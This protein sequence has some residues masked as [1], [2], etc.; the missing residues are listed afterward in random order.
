MSRSRQP[1]PDVAAFTWFLNGLTRPARIRGMEGEA[2]PDPVAQDLLATADLAGLLSQ[3]HALDVR[4]LRPIGYGASSVAFDARHGLALR[5]GIGEPVE[6][7]RIAGVIHPLARGR[8]GRGP[9]R[10][11]APGGHGRHHRGRRPGPGRAAF[12]MRPGKSS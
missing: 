7:P 9:L 2:V 1:I 6:V 4:N 3:L 5:L 8:A 12:R 11:H 10:A